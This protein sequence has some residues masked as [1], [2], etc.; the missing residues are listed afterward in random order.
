MDGS[1][2]NGHPSDR[3]GNAG[4]SLDT[5]H[6]ISAAQIGVSFS[7]TK[8]STDF[9][10]NTPTVFPRHGNPD[11]IAFFAPLPPFDSSDHNS[12][13]NESEGANEIAFAPASFPAGLNNGVFIGFDG[14]YDKVGA[15]NTTTGAGNEENPV[16]YYDLTSGASWHFIGT[17][18]AYIG[19]P[20]GLLATSDAL[21]IADLSDGSLAGGPT[22]MGAIYKVTIVCHQPRYDADGDSD[23]DVD[24]FGAFQKCFGLTATGGCACFDQSG[25]GAIDADDFA[26]FLQCSGAGAAG[27]DVPADPNC[28]R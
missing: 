11:A 9:W 14:Q 3:Y 6:R 7:G 25:N 16:I 21:F 10:E 28:A 8:F 18:E 23:V 13:P 27:S 19:H 2:S 17:Q 1:S 4:Y 26:A 24:D 5:L 22:N 15:P 12:S 20:V